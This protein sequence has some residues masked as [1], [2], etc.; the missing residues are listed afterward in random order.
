MSTSVSSSEI[1]SEDHIPDLVSGDYSNAYLRS[2]AEKQLLIIKPDQDIFINCNG[3]FDKGM[4]SYVTRLRTFECER[5]KEKHK[6]LYKKKE[7]LSSAGFYFIGYRDNDDKVVCFYCE[8]NLF[9]WKD[10]DNP[11]VEHACA[12]PDCS[13]VK[14][15]K[16][17]EFIRQASIIKYDE[18]DEQTY[19]KSLDNKEREE[20]KKTELELQVKMSNPNTIDQLSNCLV[21]DLGSR[22]IAFYPC[23]HLTTCI[24]WA[25]QF[26]EC[27]VCRKRIH[28]YM[29]L[30]IA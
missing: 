4:I 9:E 24:D 14:L 25:A 7:E 10:D 28:A 11:W 21:C 29:K 26:E 19:Y 13:F 22:R 12:Y 1:D 3:P 15:I 2:R 8:G 17:E 23:H 30:F 18:I 16:G 6:V 27:I 20:R 5:V